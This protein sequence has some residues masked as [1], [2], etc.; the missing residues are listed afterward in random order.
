MNRLEARDLLAP[1]V[2]SLV[3]H[4]AERIADQAAE[5]IAELVL[6]RI[7]VD[8]HRALSAAEK[9]RQL[10]ISESTVRRLHREGRLDA[11][12]MGEHRGLRFAAAEMPHDPPA[13]PTPIRKGVA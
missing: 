5:R 8:Q 1:V 6:A 7:D 3:D 2:E 4:L 13:P 12:P 9:A 11:L 10:G